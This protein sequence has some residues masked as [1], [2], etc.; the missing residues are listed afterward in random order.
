MAPR[1][2]LPEETIQ[3]GKERSVVER[4]QRWLNMGL[5][6]SCDGAENDFGLIR[7]ELVADSKRFAVREVPH[8][9][10]GAFQLAFDIEAAGLVAVKIPQTVAHLSP[11]MK[12]LNAAVLSGRFHHDGNP[13]LTWMMANV[14]AKGTPTR[15]FSPERNATN[16]D[17]WRG[18]FDYGSQP[19]NVLHPSHRIILG[20][21]MKI[22]W[23]WKRKASNTYELWQEIYGGRK[24]YSGHSVT[25][26]KAL[27]VS[28][29]LACVKVIAE[30]LPRCL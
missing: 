14:V 30:G 23:P 28:A 16:Q 15:T 26:D 2:Y 3:Y 27:Q 4:Y 9:P 1:F 12:E 13:I 10:W 24:S 20:K 21:P 18:G 25:L 17:R 6:T 22:S 7:D 11:A 19:G 8:D 5:L 29:V